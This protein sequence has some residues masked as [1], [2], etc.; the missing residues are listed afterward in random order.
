[1]K[2]HMWHF[3]TRRSSSVVERHLGK[4]EVESPI[5][6]SGS[7]INKENGDRKMS[8]MGTVTIVYEIVCH[9]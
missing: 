2:T 1:M 4:M 9:S 3:L 5:L 8:K 7:K 6:S